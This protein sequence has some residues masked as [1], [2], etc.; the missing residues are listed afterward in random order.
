MFVSE[1]ERIY[2]QAW[3]DYKK[4]VLPN[5]GGSLDQPMKF[6]LLMNIIEGV[7]NKLEEQEN[8]SRG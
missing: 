3:A 1:Y 6:F 7:M 2:I 4:G 5:D 8:Q